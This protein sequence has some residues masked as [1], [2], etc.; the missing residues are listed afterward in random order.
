MVASPSMERW[1]CE[2]FDTEW[3]RLREGG[4]SPSELSAATCPPAPV[5]RD[6]LQLLMETHDRPA[7]DLRPLI[8]RLFLE[9]SF[10]DSNGDTCVDEGQQ[11]LIERQV[12]VLVRV[13]E[14]VRQSALTSGQW[15]TRPAA[16]PMFG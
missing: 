13:L 7:S 1:A 8:R 3:R 9:K 4:T 11:R 14:A 15:C 2:L 12:E 16:T 5:L 6:L 10:V